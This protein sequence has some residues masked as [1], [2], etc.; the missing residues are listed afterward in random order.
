MF[1]L[2]MMYIWRRQD[3]SMFAGHDVNLAFVVVVGVSAIWQM[4][5][6]KQRLWPLGL[7]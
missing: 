7:I 4:G 3:K 1:G 5:K 6:M 2:K